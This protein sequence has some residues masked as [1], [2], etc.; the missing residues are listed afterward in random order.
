VGGNVTG[1]IKTDGEVFKNLNQKREGFPQFD[2]ICPK[3]D[4]KNIADGS[5]PPVQAALPQTLPSI[6]EEEKSLFE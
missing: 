1:T 4:Y 3:L 2:T 6:V 5:T